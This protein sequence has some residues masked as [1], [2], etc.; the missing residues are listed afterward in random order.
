MPTS[1]KNRNI[2]LFK[3]SWKTPLKAGFVQIFV[4][5]LKDSELPKV[6]GAKRQEFR[7]VWI[8]EVFC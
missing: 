1:G 7:K 4:L 8:L 6:L 2:Y 3:K 5:L